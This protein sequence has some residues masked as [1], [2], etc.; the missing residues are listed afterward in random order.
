M[1]L[2]NSKCAYIDYYDFSA[3]TG[4]CVRTK[5][6]RSRINKSTNV[7]LVIW[8]LVSALVF[9]LCVISPVLYDRL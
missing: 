9:L 2:Y 4:R 1:N 3:S 8:D 7:Y 6:E 5:L